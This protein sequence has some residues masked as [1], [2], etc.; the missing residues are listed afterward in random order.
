[1]KIVHGFCVEKAVK[2]KKISREMCSGECFL[3][4]ALLTRV[5]FTQLQ[6][7]FA[8]ELISSGRLLLNKNYFK[9]LFTKLMQSTIIII[10]SININDNE[11]RNE[12]FARS[13]IIFHTTQVGHW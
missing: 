10:I 2:E 6:D 7:Y 3:K 4:H 5:H 11:G 1:M 12:D 9:Q 13:I 8:R